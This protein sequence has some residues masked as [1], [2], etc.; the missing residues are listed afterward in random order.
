[1]ILSDFNYGCL[2]QALV[3]K[4]I[5][6]SKS[7]NIFIAS[8]SQSSSQLGDIAKFKGSDLITPTEREARLSQLQKNHDD[9]LVVLADKLMI[10]A[11]AKHILLKLGDEGMICQQSKMLMNRLIPRDLKP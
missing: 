5:K 10:K 1:M 9:G 7:K 4:I 3:D 6:L 8:D 2:P 11:E